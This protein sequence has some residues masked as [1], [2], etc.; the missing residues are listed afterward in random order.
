VRSAPADSLECRS[1]LGMDPR[2]YTLMITGASQGA[3]SINSFAVEFAL[4][5]ALM[6]QGGRANSWQ[7]IHLTGS[8]A[9][10]AVREAYAEAGVAAYVTPFL[11]DMGLAWG[12]ADLAISRAGASSVAE[13]G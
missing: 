10:E 3:T 12:A 13:A 11:N 6:F 1:R 9:D 4:A 5:N 8:G 2:R 7:I